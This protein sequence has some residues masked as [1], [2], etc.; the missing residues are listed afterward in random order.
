MIGLRGLVSELRRSNVFRM[1]ALQVVA[2]WL[3]MQ[4]AE[5][6][7]DLANL[8]DWVVPTVLGLLALGLPTATKTAVA[9]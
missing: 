9:A 6:V 5:V 3:I 7:K 2:A 1:A 4:V 8:P